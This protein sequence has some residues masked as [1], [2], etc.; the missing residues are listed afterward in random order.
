MILSRALLLLCLASGCARAEV[1]SLAAS[2]LYTQTAHACSD[3]D[4]ATWHHPAEAVLRRA[5]MHVSK[6]QLCNGRTY[7]VFTVAPKFD[8]RGDTSSI[9]HPF[10]AKLAAA[11]GWWSYALVDDTDKVIVT[12]DV[13]KNPRGLTIHYENFR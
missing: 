7:P 12:V 3:V 11:N 13:V 10:Y 1:P 6:V 5:D 4:L 9:Y 8:P 2:M